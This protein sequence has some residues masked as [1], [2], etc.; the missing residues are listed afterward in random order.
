M[1]GKKSPPKSKYRS[2]SSVYLDFAYN[3]AYITME[4]ECNDVIT[5]FHMY[6]FCLLK[7]DG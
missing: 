2:R 3:D 5:I 1:A 7:W 6:H 4:Q